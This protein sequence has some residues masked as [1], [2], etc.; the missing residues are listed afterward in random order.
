MPTYASRLYNTSF[1]LPSGAS[2]GVS[3]LISAVMQGNPELVFP[4]GRLVALLAHSALD[5]GVTVEL[6]SVWTDAFGNRQT[7]VLVQEATS[8]PSLA[9]AA[10]P[11]VGSAIE[12][13]IHPSHDLPSGTSVSG[14]C[15]LW[16]A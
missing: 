1:T 7:T 5:L 12:I 14:V 10:A 15:S 8:H 13:A 4:T 9:L 11:F 3:T 6:R 16:G 2:A